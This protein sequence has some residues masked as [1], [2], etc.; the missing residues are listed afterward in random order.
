V[1]LNSFNT[2]KVTNMAS[3]FE[4]CS[5][6]TFLDLTAFYTLSV[7]NMDKMFAHCRALKTIYVY[8]DW[9][10]ENVKTN[11]NMFTGC[12]VLTGEYG[13]RYNASRPG[14]FY[15]RLDAKG[16]PGYLTYKDYV[17]DVSAIPSVH[18]RSFD[19]YD[20]QGV[21]VRTAEQGIENLPSGFYII[22]NRKIY[23]K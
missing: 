19:I 23:V 13:T 7:T 1:N 22:G 12:N 8:R 14:S 9:T 4:N 20:V 5:S 17:S 21:K 10:I 18:D 15:A 16:A 11:T 2:D 3:M 6:L